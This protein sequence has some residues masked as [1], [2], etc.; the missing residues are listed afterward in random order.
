[1]SSMES[2]VNVTFNFVFS[3][4]INAIECGELESSSV[5]ISFDDTN[6]DIENEIENQLSTINL[7]AK[8]DYTKYLNIAIETLCDCYYLQNKML[9]C[10]NM[11]QFMKGID[12][13]LYEHIENYMQL[14]NNAHGSIHL[15]SVLCKNMVDTN[16]QRIDYSHFT[17]SSIQYLNLHITHYNS[18]ID[19]TKFK[20]DRDKLN[21][22]INA[23]H[24]KIKRNTRG[25]IKASPTVI[26]N[27]MTGI[28]TLDKL[29]CYDYCTLKYLLVIALITKYYHERKVETN[30]Y[31]WLFVLLCVVAVIL[32]KI[33]I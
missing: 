21:I 4:I 13:D 28:W 6:K 29:D 19:S 17:K 25:Y 16:V 26:N 33:L 15:N 12:I 23:L 22:I 5:K 7:L 1:M 31:P 8:T 20:Y 32:Y 14:I 27:L 10:D 30:Y 18:H 3:Q 9:M 2:R 24:M 11:I